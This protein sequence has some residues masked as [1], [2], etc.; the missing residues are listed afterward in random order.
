MFILWDIFSKWDA[1]IYFKYIFYLMDVFQ[2]FR[3]KFVLLLQIA[4][5]KS[6]SSI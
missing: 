2:K 3:F 4:Y 6:D 1:F 5:L